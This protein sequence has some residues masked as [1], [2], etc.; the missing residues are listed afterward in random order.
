MLNKVVLEYIPKYGQRLADEVRKWGE[1]IKREAEKELAE[2]Y[3]KDPDGSTPIAYLWAR[4]ILSE[5][6]G[7]GEIPVEVPLMRS[8]WLAKKAGRRRALCGGCAMRRTRSRPR[9]S[10]S[11]TSRT[12]S[13]F[14]KRV[15]RPLLEIFEPAKESDVEGGTV[16]RGSATCPVTGFTTTVDRVRAQLKSRRGGAADSPAVLCRHH[17]QVGTRAVLPTADE[18]RSGGV[19]RRGGGTGAAREGRRNTAVAEGTAGG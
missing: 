10:R 4:T 16:A 9:P 12:D 5:A 6:P 15:K 7:E 11:R 3:P 2:F 18:G 8:L 17:P 13:A 19:R 1:W 14:L